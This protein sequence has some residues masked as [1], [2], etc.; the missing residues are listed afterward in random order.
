MILLVIMCLHNNV[1]VTS[2]AE[3]VSTANYS[4][5][6]DNDELRLHG[7][8][9][10][11]ILY[12][13][14]NIA[15][16]LNHT[17]YGF[18]YNGYKLYF[19]DSPI[20]IDGLIEYMLNDTIILYEDGLDI[21]PI[22]NA[23]RTNSYLTSVVSCPELKLSSKAISSYITNYD[24]TDYALIQLDTGDIGIIYRTVAPEGITYTV[25]DSVT[26]DWW[27]SPLG[28]LCFSDK[29]QSFALDF[30]SISTIYMR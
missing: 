5:N 28:M 29:S 17:T 9:G 16:G 26:G 21:Q 30:T 2:H 24:A 13:T 12:Y 25:S 20:T 10:L 3:E 22:L 18:T 8:Q 27:I 1:S 11:N 7:L 14:D 4:L 23:V 19:T 6:F 15:L